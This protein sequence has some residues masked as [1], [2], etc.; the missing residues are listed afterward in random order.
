MVIFA[1]SGMVIFA[2]MGLSIDA[3]VSYLQSDRLERAAASA[4]LAG[5]AY[6]PGDYSSAQNAALVE[7]ARN[8][9]TNAGS[10][11]SCPGNPSPCV[12]TAQPATNELKVTISESVP[13]TFLALLGFGNH[14]VARSATAIFLPP[15]ALGQPGSQQGSAM[16]SPCDGVGSGGQ[17]CSNPSS[18][19]GSGGSNY[20]FERTEGWGNPRSEGDA[21]TPSPD[22]TSSICGPSS[23]SCVASPPDYHQISPMVGTEPYFPS[24]NADLALNYTGGY[25]YLVAVP[26]G[27]SADVQIYDPSFAPDSHDQTTHYSYHEDDSS[28][29]N[30]STTNTDYAAMAY[31]VFQVPTLSSYASDVPVSQEIFYPFNASGLYGQSSSTASYY[32]FPHS[33]ASGEAAGCTGTGTGAQ[34][35]VTRWI[36][37]VYHQ[38]ISALQASS[39]LT[40]SNDKALFCDALSPGSGVYLKNTNAAGGATMYWRLE[41]DTLQWNGAPTCTSSGCSVPATTG[42]NNGQS[43]AHKGYAVRVAAAPAS[44]CS[45]CTISALSDM[46]VYT[47]IIS[48]SSPLTFGIPLFQ[49]DPAYAGRTIEVDI[50]DPGD[51]GGG[52]AYMGVQQP[53]GSWATASITALGNSIGAGGTTTVQQNWQGNTTVCSACFQTAYSNGGSIYNGQWLQLAVTVPTSLSNW[54]NYWQLEYSV[55]SGVTAGDT[56][57]V[58]VSSAGS[59]DHL[60]P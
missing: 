6:L 54:S 32:Y 41:V 17:Y 38:W 36:P 45:G 49:L 44:T 55:S 42:G 39:T 27:Q 26:P 3:G 56:F 53:D 9:Y 46:T 11:N 60:L 16:A 10:G 25:N 33:N 28:F 15:I 35:T 18:G 24:S 40:N 2:I 58:E 57:S 12:V 47:P 1:L 51:V 50:F 29:P 8:G 21:L 34:T 43:R 7:A 59:P 48:G 52:A 23:V 4:A 30:G 31:T 13:T 37:T 14:T 22:E 5:V 20:Y 19:L